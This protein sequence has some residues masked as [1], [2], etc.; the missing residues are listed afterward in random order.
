VAN[1]I[2]HIQVVKRLAQTDILLSWQTRDATTD[3]LYQWNGTGWTLLVALPGTGLIYDS[4]IL[5]NKVYWA[6]GKNPIQVWK[7]DIDETCEVVDAPVVQYLVTYQGRIVGGGDA[8]TKAEVEAD[9]QVWPA[10][11]N[12]DRVVYCEPLDDTLWSP[13]N[14]IDCNFDNGEVISGLGINSINSAT[15][16]AQSQLVVFKP[17]ATLVNDGALS[18]AEQRLN[19]AS[20]VLGC[21][22][23]HSIKNTPHGLIFASKETVC[24]MDTSGKEPTQIGFLISPQMKLIPVA[25]QKWMAAIFHENT[26]K[27]S[28]SNAHA[29]KNNEEWWLD[30]KPQIFP[31]EHNWYGPMTGDFILQYGIFSGDLVGAEMLTANMWK[32][33]VE[34]SYGSMT[35]PA[36][37]R[38]QVM[39]WPRFQADNLTHG[40]VDA[41][42]FRG[43]AGAAAALTFTE[44]LSLDQGN[45]TTSVSFVTPADDAIYNVTRPFRKMKYDGQ[46]SISHTSAS[47]LEIQSLYLRTKLSRRQSEH[48][49]GGSQTRT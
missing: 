33:D 30:L 34:G 22:G 3:A 32:L 24:L 16:G 2:K 6:D 13:N 23:Y 17:T 29:T 28:F 39:T 43:V 14:F 41:Y 35:T 18:A 25:M 27:L 19:I 5:Q 9:S 11:S 31:Q 36:T 44:T 42:G 46:V 8:R 45:S 37:P 12:Q 20:A 48:L 15:R 10:D 21:P 47:D 40:F 1:V 38:T 26:Y 7:P 4:T 49:S